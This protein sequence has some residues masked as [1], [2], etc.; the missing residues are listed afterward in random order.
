LKI[1][2]RI[3][4]VIIIFSAI[5]LTLSQ[6]INKEAEPK[7]LRGEAFAGAAKCAGCHASIHSSYLHS[8]HNL[9]S[10][11]G[12]ASSIKGSFHKDSNTYYYN[13]EVK[14]V[15]QQR[16]SGFYQVAYQGEVEKQ[17]N[18]IDLVI[19]SGRKAQTYLYWLDDKVFQLPVSWFVPVKSWVNSPGYPP[20]QV[21]FDRN[22]P[23]GCFGCH[24]SHIKL[25]RNE[26]A[27][28]RIINNFDRNSIIYGIDCERC[29]GPAARHV[30]FHQENPGDKQAKYVVSYSTLNRQQQIDMCALCH[31][32][33]Q[34]QVKSAFK[35]RPGELLANNY[36]ATVQSQDPEELDVHGNQT[37]LL[38]ASACFIKSNSLTCTSCHNTHVN[39]RD[40]LPLFSKRCMNCHSEAKNNF[41]KKA[42]EIGPDII[43][44]CIDC[45]MPE[46]PSKL[47]TLLS[48]GQPNPIANK[49][50]THLI[51]V[52]GEKSL[53][54]DR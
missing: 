35:F 32:G 27:G 6:C 44:N 39:E 33:V 50:R 22:I 53:T 11:A 46:K 41:C 16:D 38:M 34:Q 43:N 14:L 45:H 52:Y 23:I 31:S 5:V 12:N 15:M 19:G 28:D 49:V 10:S 29:H 3:L 9:S 24:S 51:K 47:I 13:K 8:A 48:N 17:A 7:D 36:F 40:N 4:V 37:Q 25:T 30:K 42:H 26:A 54:V 18:R 2:K 21:R 20:R 1:R